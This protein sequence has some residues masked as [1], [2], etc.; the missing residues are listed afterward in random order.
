MI[1]KSEISTILTN[2]QVT[3]RVLFV[4]YR[5]FVQNHPGERHLWT[6]EQEAMH[7]LLFDYDK[8]KLH[9]ESTIRSVTIPGYLSKQDPKVCEKATF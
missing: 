9:F 4:N 8:H 1:E 5:S 6:S 3:V 7:V 2:L